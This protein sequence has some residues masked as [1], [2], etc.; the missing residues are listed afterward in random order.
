MFYDDLHVVPVRNIDL[1]GPD[2]P[3]TVDQLADF[4]PDRLLLNIDEDM[5]SQRNWR[6]LM[7]SKLWSDLRSVRNSRVDFL[8]S[9]P[10]VE[11]TAFTHELMLDEVLKIWRDRA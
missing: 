3:I 5:A 4:D 10:W 7:N 9:Y 11:Y 6:T 2:Q 1:M 8:P